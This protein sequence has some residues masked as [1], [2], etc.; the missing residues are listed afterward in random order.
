MNTSVANLPA[1]PHRVSMNSIQTA[2]QYWS[3]RRARDIRRKALAVELAQL[4][5][6]RRVDRNAVATVLP[7]FTEAQAGLSGFPVTIMHANGTR[8][9]CNYLR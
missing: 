6:Q 7:G 2:S 5:Y 1:V 3:T 8:T 9:V 4:D